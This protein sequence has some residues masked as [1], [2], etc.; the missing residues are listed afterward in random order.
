MTKEEFNEE[1]CTK[2][3]N[4]NDNCDLDDI[5]IEERESKD[6]G[7]YKRAVCTGYKVWTNFI[8]RSFRVLDWRDGRDG[9]R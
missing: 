6:G 5:H 2:C 1:M 4:C 8:D 7:K 3:I 9:E